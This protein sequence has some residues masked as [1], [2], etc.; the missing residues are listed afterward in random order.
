[1][2]PTYAPPQVRRRRRWP[3]VLLIVLL[4]LVGLA[5]AA[6]RIALSV[7]EDRAASA[8][9]SSQGLSHKPDVTVE[10][11]PFLTQLV[12]GSFG[13][14][15]VSANDVTVGQAHDLQIN[16]VVVDLHD[17]TVPSDYSSVHADTATAR[18]SIGYDALSRE[19]GTEVRAGSGGRLIAEPS[20]HILGQ[21]F[22]G[23]V[24]AVVHASSANGLSFDNPKVSVNGVN[25]PSVVA[26]ILARVF[27]RSISLAGL[28]FHVQVTGVDVTPDALVIKLAGHDLTYRR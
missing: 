28:P 21:K 4:V 16:Q 1:M 17:V 25:A 7:A 11:F 5:V 18:G 10:G 6:D 2:V 14:V 15:I 23:T 19:L 22:T 24:S 20:V 13:E 8:L 9:Q 12:A 3:W 27:E 26:R